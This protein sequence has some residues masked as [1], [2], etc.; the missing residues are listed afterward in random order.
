MFQKCHILALKTDVSEVSSSGTV[1]TH[2][3]GSIFWHCEDRHFRGLAF[4]RTW[5]LTRT[6]W[7]SHFVWHSTKDRYWSSQLLCKHT[8]KL[9]PGYD[10]TCSFAF[11]RTCLQYGHNNS[12]KASG[13]ATW[14]TWPHTV[15]LGCACT[16]IV[17]ALWLTSAGKEGYSHQQFTQVIWCNIYI[18]IRDV[19]EYV[20]TSV[21]P[22]LI[23]RD[24]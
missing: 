9:N 7:F 22:C 3:R 4:V 10:T 6:E 16:C 13:L 18:F 1:K 15:V 21:K 8:Q 2:F 19:C 5:N 23:V 24:D 14:G 11:C 12:A 17:A 20:H